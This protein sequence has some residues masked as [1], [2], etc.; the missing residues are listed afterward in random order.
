MAYAPNTTNFA[1]HGDDTALGCFKN[2][3]TDA[4]FEFTM[5]FGDEAR[6]YPHKVWMTDGSFR[7]ALVKKTVAYIIV[8]EDEKGPVIEK[9]ALKGWQDY[10][11][12][13]GLEARS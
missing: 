3:E 12:F 13:H 9:W 10:R 8:N 11:T 6:A 4:F 5:D 1:P 2:Q 7:M